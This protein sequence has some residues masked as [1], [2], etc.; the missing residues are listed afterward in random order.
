M[1]VTLL[2]ALQLK[3]EIGYYSLPSKHHFLLLRLLLTKTIQSA[4]VL[5]QYIHAW[6]VFP[7]P[8]LCLAT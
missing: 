1:Q 5:Q 2:F 7:K 4:G 6:G 8:V 3:L